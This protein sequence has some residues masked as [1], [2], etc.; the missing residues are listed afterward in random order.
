MGAVGPVVA[1]AAERRQV[2][3]VEVRAALREIAAIKPHA[4]GRG[5][6][7]EGTARIVQHKNDW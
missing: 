6:L 2:M 1:A 7:G 3:K 4:P 5:T